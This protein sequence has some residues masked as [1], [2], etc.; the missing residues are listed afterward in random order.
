MSSGFSRQNGSIVSQFPSSNPRTRSILLPSI[1]F[2]SEGPPPTTD[3]PPT[4]QHRLRSH[5]RGRQGR[6]RRRAAHVAYNYRAAGWADLNKDPTSISPE[7]RRPAA[8]PS[9]RPSTSNLAPRH[10]LL[11]RVAAEV[12]REC[13]GTACAHSPPLRHVTAQAATSDGR[14]C[15]AH[16]YLPQK[17]SNQPLT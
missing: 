5:R 12:K 6:W 15:A 9:A 13:S 10:P 14:A 3:P 17:P 2:P 8:V 11:S 1:H 4:H 7:R 16:A